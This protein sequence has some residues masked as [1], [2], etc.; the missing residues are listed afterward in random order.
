[1]L[2]V[3]GIYEKGQ[4]RFLEHIS[5][6]GKFDVIITFLEGRREFSAENRLEGLL[7]DLSE[8]DFRDFSESCQEDWFGGRGGRGSQ[9]AGH[10][11]KVAGCNEPLTTNNPQPT[12][13]K[14]Q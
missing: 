9:V 13:Y 1:M 12:T 14:Y 3:P 11:L 2:S 7:S 10:R 6:Q 5:R 4:I 8:D